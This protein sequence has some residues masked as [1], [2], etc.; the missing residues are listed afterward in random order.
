[1]LELNGLKYSRESF[2]DYK[3]RAIAVLK[4]D[5]E[6]YRLDIYTNDTDK[7]NLTNV[8]VG[9]T[10]TGVDFVKI[11]HWATKEHDEMQNKMLD[12]WLSKI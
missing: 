6:L 10:K 5:G 8:L 9:K 2:E 7:S 3:Y 11:D 12:E 1:M 4:K